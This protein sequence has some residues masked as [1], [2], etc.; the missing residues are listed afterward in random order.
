MAEVLEFELFRVSLVTAPPLIQKLPPA[1]NTSAHRAST[2]LLLWAP[3]AAM[4][5]MLNA[6]SDAMLAPN[7]E[8]KWLV[9]LLLGSI[10]SLAG[11]L[12]CF[13]ECRQGESGRKGPDPTPL[14]IP[15]ILFALFFVGLAAGV[16]YTVNPGE[17]INR[18]GFWCSGGV[19]FLAVAWAAGHIPN[20]SRL[21]QWALAISASLLSGLFWYGYF[22]DFPRPEFNKFVM[23]SPIGH[24]NFTADVLM[25]LIPF[26]VWTLVTAGAMLRL[27]AGLSLATA[28]FMLLTS[29]SLGG[30]GGLVAG[31]AVTLSLGAAKI[32]LAANTRS[33]RPRKRSAII[34]LAVIALTALATKPIYERMPKEYRE[35]MFVH[36]EWSAPPQTEDFKS[37]KNLPPLAALWIGILPYLGSRTPMWATT[38]GMVAAHP[39]LGWGTGSYLFEYPGFSKRYDPFR[40]F[41]TLGVKVK[42][43]PHNVVLQIASENGIPMALL[44]VGL[45]LWLTV[46]VMRQAWREPSALWLCGTWALWA[47]GLDAQINHVFFNPASLFMAAV[48]FGFLYGRLPKPKFSSPLLAF[49]AWRTPI[50]PA[51][52]SVLVLTIAS[53][54]L[55]WLVSEYHVAKALRLESSHPPASKQQIRFTWETAFDWS[56]TNVQAIYGLAMLYADHGLPAQAE[57][58]LREFL[59]LSPHHS[60]GLNLLAKLQADSG[61]LDEAESTLLEALQLEPDAT[62]VKE[63]LNEL[64][65]AKEHATGH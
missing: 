18:L 47:A 8:P 40:D 11:T 60:V 41:E 32:S 23:F 54:P 12:H 37:A 6:R 17:G 42:T 28:G 20:Y 59:E 64:R 27:L 26:L 21:L 63:N 48:G 56:P 31:A 16:T 30:M 19:T 45:Y 35:Q 62:A 5:L 7:E 44:F 43:N 1:M 38:A 53:N 34:S 57:T 13:L 29:G 50:A 36:G 2:A 9:F 10:L 14:S 49:L 3:L 58:K 52:A 65:K 61:K 39:W 22:S 4:P 51:L 33:W 46:K 24:F 25:V 55:R 15:G